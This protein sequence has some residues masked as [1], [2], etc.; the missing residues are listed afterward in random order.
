MISQQK[1]PIDFAKPVCPTVHPRVK[2]QKRLNELRNNGHGVPLEFLDKIPISI[3][4]VTDLLHE[5]LGDSA[6]ASSASFTLTLGVP[7]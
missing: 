1:L 5:A 4:T 3:L 7:N 2:T 6:S